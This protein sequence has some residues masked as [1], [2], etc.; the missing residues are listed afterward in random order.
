MSS[1]RTLLSVIR[2]SLSLVLAVLLLVVGVV[3]FGDL[4]SRAE[5]L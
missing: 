2:T 1:D 4:A 5:P 3:A